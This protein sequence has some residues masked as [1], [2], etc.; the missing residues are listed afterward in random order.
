MD[1]LDS[2]K[3]FQELI[4]IG[5]EVQFK[6]N[7]KRWLVEPDQD[8][9]E[10]SEKRQLISTEADNLDFIKKFKDT[11]EFLNYSICGKVI[12][13]SWKEITDIDY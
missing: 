5:Y 7:N 4:E 10:F 6:L 1:N 13:D 8:A 11:S 12:K 9:P 3:Q 2:L